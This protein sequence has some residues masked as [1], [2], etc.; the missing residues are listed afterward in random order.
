MKLLRTIVWVALAA[1]GT[2]SF[3][4][5]RGLAL[6][7]H[8]A[9]L[10]ARDQTEAARLEALSAQEADEARAAEE[11]ARQDYATP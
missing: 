10:A 8:E 7:Y 1:C 5:H 2:T 6:R 11:L 4:Q 9:A 3:E